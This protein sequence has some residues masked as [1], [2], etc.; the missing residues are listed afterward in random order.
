MTTVSDRSEPVVVATGL[1]KSYSGVR[2]LQDVSLSLAQGEI[3]SLVGE[4]GAG[5]STLIKLLSGLVLPDSGDVTLLGKPLPS[6][7]AAVESAGIVTVQQESNAF[8]DL[9]IPDNIYVG[10]EVRRGLF[11]DKKAMVLRSKE[12]LASLGVDLPVNVPVSDL[13]VAQRQMVG[14]ARALSLDSRLLI[15]DEPTASL[16]SKEVDTLHATVRRLKMQGVAVLFVS[17]RLEE[18]LELSDQITVLRDGSLVTT[19]PVGEWTKPSLIQAMVGKDLATNG[20]DSPQAGDIVLDVQGLTTDRVRDVS[21]DVRAGEVVGLGGLVGAGRSEVVRAIFGVDP[22]VS[23]TVTV[24]GKP[25]ARS[26]EGAVAAGVALVPEDRQHQGLVLDLPVLDNVTMAMRPRLARSGW[27]DRKGEAALAKEECARLS[28]KSS[29]PGA[30]AKSLSGGNQ[31]KVVI[32]K[33]LATSPKLLIL[34]EPTRGVDVG[35]KSEIHRIVRE[36]AADGAAV[37]IV[38]SDLPELVDLSDRVYVMR[39]GEIAGEL[40]GPE[41]S[42]ESV[43]HLAFGEAAS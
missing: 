24:A 18:V 38:S 42:Q 27:I 5:K 40:V 35:S 17:H 22:I 4:N 12:L 20:K 37:L 10:R 7:V 19:A 23:G 41:V 25:V 16:S 26:I 32:G 30:R 2:A 13:S 36:L 39:S 9:T 43:L 34:D 6:G 14:I 1:S 33:W 29:G 15:L 31:Q 28:V 21:L 3:H 8:P 11:L